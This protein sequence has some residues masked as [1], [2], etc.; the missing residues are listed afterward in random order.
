MS[1]PVVLGYKLSLIWVMLYVI[2]YT[3]NDTAVTATSG[4]LPGPTT[5][6][7]R[8]GAGLTKLVKLHHVWLN[9]KMYGSGLCSAPGSACNCFCACQASDLGS[10]CLIFSGFLRP[11]QALNPINS[12]FRNQLKTSLDP[13]PTLNMIRFLKVTI[14]KFYIGIYYNKTTKKRGSSSL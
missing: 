10:E 8:G 12:T 6:P 3:I 9:L 7:R 13:Y 1:F 4:P 2:Y 11:G 14:H 5:T